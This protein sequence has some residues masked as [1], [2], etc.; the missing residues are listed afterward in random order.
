MDKVSVIERSQWCLVAGFCGL[1]PLLG[2]GPAVVAIH[3]YHHTRRMAHGEWN[4]A[5][6]YAKGGLILGWCGVVSFTLT[7]GSLLQKAL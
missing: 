1:L 2:L 5:G 6:A 3:L 7:L 4:P